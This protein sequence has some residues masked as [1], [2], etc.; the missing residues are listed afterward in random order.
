MNMFTSVLS[1]IDY[2]QLVFDPLKKGTD[3]FLISS[4][5]IELA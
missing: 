2:L 5:P 4:L 3:R 1:V